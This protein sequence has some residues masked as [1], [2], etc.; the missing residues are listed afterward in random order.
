MSWTDIG[1]AVAGLP[2]LAASLYLLAL[3]ILSRRQPP[4]AVAAPRMRFD[5]V[6]PA[7]DEDAQINRTVANLLA[8]AYPRPLFRVLVIADNCCDRTAE[9]AAAAGAQVI[10]RNDPEHRG[11][12]YALAH[13]FDYSLAH[14]FA[15]AVVVVDADTIVTSNLLSAFSARFEAGAAALQADYGVRNPMASWRTRMM[16]IALSAFHGVRSL[17]REHLQL[18]CGLRGNGMGFSTSLL[19]AEPHHAFSIVEDL[20]YGLQLGSAGYR[21]E[22][23]HEARVLGQ[24]VST[25][26]ASRSQ[27]RRWEKGR[28]IL[29]RQRGIPLLSQAWTKRSPLLL[30]LALDLLVPPLGE[31]VA[32]DAV[33]LT[34]TI[35]LTPL[36]GM[37]MWIWSAS[38]FGVAV[39]GIRAWALSGVGPRGLLDLL[40][41]P[42][43]VVWKL[44]LLFKHKDA[45]REEWIRTTREVK[46]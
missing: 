14:G 5:I 36:G 6:V 38:A 9:Y 45:R 18:S 29:A 25:E 15:D 12:G 31:L 35:L 1:L 41:T 17:A 7:H 21:V 8:L 46:M 27:R 4:R 22:Y 23:V 33:G 11:K 30:D 13:A 42:V 16:T 34:L 20:E 43:Y 2:T 39:Y 40:W 3:A 37:A 44:T 10:V 26:H 32:L 24:M 28:R 19:R